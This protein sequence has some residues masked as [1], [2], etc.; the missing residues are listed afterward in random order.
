MKGTQGNFKLGYFYND[1][2]S[3]NI[4][5]EL[6]GMRLEMVKQGPRALEIS[7]E[8]QCGLKLRRI[9]GA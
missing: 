5:N 3:S 2:A 4:E 6:E 7:D 9:D 8:I 1:N